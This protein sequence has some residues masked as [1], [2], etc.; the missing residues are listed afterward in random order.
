MVP[1]YWPSFLLVNCYLCVLVLLSET[2]LRSNKTL[3]FKNT[4]W[5]IR[6]GTNSII[7]LPDHVCFDIKLVF[8]LDFEYCKI[9][10][11]WYHAENVH[12]FHNVVSSVLT[13]PHPAKT[14]YLQTFHY[15]SNDDEH[16]LHASLHILWRLF[17][18]EKSHLRNCP[19]LKIGR[20]KTWLKLTLSVVVG[21][22][23]G[24]FGCLLLTGARVLWGGLEINL[25]KLIS[26]ST[27]YYTTTA[28]T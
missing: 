11:L 26:I 8:L 25:Y 22:F 12:W 16:L 3:T 20:R 1:I 18:R 7:S 14:N 5:F 17:S 13:P 24:G 19:M 4:I 2:S 21:V 15:C 6:F 9:S 10:S 27:T 28:T 23:G